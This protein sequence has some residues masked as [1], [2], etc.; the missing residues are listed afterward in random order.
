MR[1]IGTDAGLQAYALK[2]VGD[3]PEETSALGSQQTPG[4]LVSLSQ[5]AQEVQ[6]VKDHLNT[7]SEVR[8]ERV[9]EI[10]GRLGRGDYYVTAKELA[11]AILASGDLSPANW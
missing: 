5:L 7:L 9:A 11:D 6:K 10:R 8:E 2:V 1:I 3:R 4:D